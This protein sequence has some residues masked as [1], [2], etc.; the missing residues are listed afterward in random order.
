MI[1]WPGTLYVILILCFTLF[2]FCHGRLH[3]IPSSSCLC[4]ICITTSGDSTNFSSCTAPTYTSLPDLRRN[5]C[6]RS[7]ILAGMKQ[8]LY[9]NKAWCGERSQFPLWPHLC[10]LFPNISYVLANFHQCGNGSIETECLSVLCASCQGTGRLSGES[11]LLFCHKSSSVEMLSSIFKYIVPGLTAK[12]LNKTKNLKGT[13]RGELTN[14]T[15]QN[16]FLGYCHKKDWRAIKLTEQW[17]A[18]IWL[19][20]RFKGEDFCNGSNNQVKK[21]ANGSSKHHESFR[22]A[23]SWSF[24]LFLTL[25]NKSCLSLLE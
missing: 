8:K 23:H 1:A 9:G 25:T 3:F 4:L 11:V 20:W 22:R 14:N 17:K 21:L 24:S 19:T 7:L 6:C 10:W 16:I 15:V 18:A 13:G 2:S 5:P 12:K